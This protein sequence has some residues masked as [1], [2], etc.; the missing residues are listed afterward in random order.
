[1]F[2]RLQSVALP[3]Y[4]HRPFGRHDFFIEGQWVCRTW[5]GASA[6]RALGL[7]ADAPS[8]YEILYLH[9]SH[10]D[11]LTGQREHR[12]VPERKGRGLSVVV[13]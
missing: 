3:R 10:T 8:F 9:G 4:R 13:A 5:R 7:E 12:R 1:M 11:W 2:P 6:F